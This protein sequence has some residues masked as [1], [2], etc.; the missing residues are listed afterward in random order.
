MTA[1]TTPQALAAEV[2]S[3]FTLPEL[4]LRALAV[5]DSPGGSAQALVEIIELD[6]GLAAT[7]LRLANSALYGYLGRVENLNHAVALIG[8]KALR[9]LVLATSA[10]KTFEDIPAEFVNMD[11]FWDNSVTCGVLAKLIARQTR[12]VE[13]DTLFLAGLL[14]GVG[15]L[16][17]YARRPEDY[18]MVLRFA[19][20][21]EAGLAAAER[22]IFGFTYARLG[23][24]LLSAWGL[25][26]RLRLA[27]EYHLEPNDAPAYKK[28]VAVVHLASAM[29]GNLAPCVKTGE[30]PPPYAAAQIQF[31]ANMGLSPQHLDTLVHET[32]A[33]SLEIIDI[34]H[35]GANTIF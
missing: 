4:A 31:A 33:A 17:F 6:A 3:L 5:M 13:S 16:V 2:S 22:H 10:V 27:V 1:S 34:I 23:A 26:E 8:H 21:G 24:A 25:P 19:H 28:E 7:V 11:S 12:L 9:D 14:H 15:R 35:P 30:T 20:D 29:A 18:R 32:L